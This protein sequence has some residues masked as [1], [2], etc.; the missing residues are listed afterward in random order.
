M[1]TV[2]HLSLPLAIL[3]ACG[4]LAVALRC[5]RSFALDLD[6]LATHN[7]VEHDCSLAHADA[8]CGSDK[9]PTRVDAGLMRSFLSHAAPKHGFSLFDFARARVDREDACGKTLGGLRAQIAQGEAA[10]AWLLLRD[11]GS[12]EID[13]DRL[14]TWWGEERLDSAWW[15]RREDEGAVGLMEA[16][17]NAVRVAGMM[18]DIRS[19]RGFSA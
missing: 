6:D 10:L 19:R 4:A 5:R 9:A 13:V 14:R 11:E 16:R 15:F 8:P 3:L 12:G 18:E 1:R 7:L 17:G 2:Y